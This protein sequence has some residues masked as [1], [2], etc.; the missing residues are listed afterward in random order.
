MRSTRLLVTRVTR[1][2]SSTGV[3]AVALALTVT[4]CMG[5][6]LVGATRLL[7]ALDPH[8]AWIATAFQESIGI[9]TAAGGAGF[10]AFAGSR[11]SAAAR[12][13]S[14]ERLRDQNRAFFS[15][16]DAI[17]DRVLDARR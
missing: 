2:L 6:V 17:V 3:A 1:L 4:A 8:P 10:A 9:L 12:R 7:A 11:H 13:R 15:Q 16:V 14:R 5:A